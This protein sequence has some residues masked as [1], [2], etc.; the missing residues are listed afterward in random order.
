MVIQN[1]STVNTQ[2]NLPNKHLTSTKIVE[3]VE[4]YAFPIYE[5][6]PQQS[7]HLVDVLG[8]NNI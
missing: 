8:F 2:R 6:N 5:V 4:M 7:A 3:L 1:K